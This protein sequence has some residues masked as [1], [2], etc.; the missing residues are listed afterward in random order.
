MIPGG[1][2]P[3]QSAVSSLAERLDVLCEVNRRLATFASL[4][5]LLAYATRCTRELF[6]AEGCALLLLDEARKEFRFPV[7]SQS[8]ASHVSS[9]GLRDIHF[10]ATQGI[11]GWVLAHGEPIVIDDAQHDPRFFPG[12]D[13]ATGTTT[14]VVLCAPLR[15]S[16]G[17]I[18][19]IE[20]INPRGRGEGDLKFLEALGS[21]VAVAHEK[22]ALYA[23]LRQEVMGLRR[24]AW[25]GGVTLGV[26]GLGLMG[27]AFVANMASAL[28]LSEFVTAPGALLGL[29]VG[30]AGL[31]LAIGVRS[32][33]SAS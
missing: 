16:Q 29:L 32:V 21:D 13:A 14:K 24:L 6:E 10:P 27:A 7:A 30:A 33:P 17:T 11:A 2:P 23:A 8:A 20:V 18:G 3:S 4:D 1:F 19:V 12:V 28:P 9:E 15:T 26:L 22:A 5:E 25:L 31:L